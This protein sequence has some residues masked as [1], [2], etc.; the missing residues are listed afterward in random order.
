MDTNPTHLSTPSPPWVSSRPKSPKARGSPFLLVTGASGYLG[1]HLVARAGSAWRLVG[2]HLSR[3]PPPGLESYR[4]DI[5]DAA[6][7]GTLLD[8]L[9]PEVVLH[10]AYRQ[11]EP[12][13]N[14]DGTRS[15][16]AACER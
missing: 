10:T 7:T 14:L 3:P 8:E 15:L 2:T 1:R 6:A 13:V 11:H 4:V 5:R 12:A 9:R 16:A